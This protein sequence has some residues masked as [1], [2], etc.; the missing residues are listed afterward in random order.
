MK[1]ILVSTPVNMAKKPTRFMAKTKKVY[2]RGNSFI[3]ISMAKKK[4]KT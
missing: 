4:P 2:P 1:K 3:S